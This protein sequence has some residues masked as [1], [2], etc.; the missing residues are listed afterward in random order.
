MKT[1]RDP[2]PDETL[3]DSVLRDE[4]WQAADATLK[5]QA[6]GAFQSGQ[7]VRRIRRLAGFAAVL[8][9]AMVIALRFSVPSSPV[10]I[11]SAA[12]P[13]GEPKSIERARDLT[14]EELLASFPEGS[15]FIAEIDGRKELIFLDPAVERIYV[16]KPLQQANLV[17][18][19]R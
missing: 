9:V 15:C 7:R 10:Q 13:A 11:Q 3:L 5:A 8:G 18:D 6:M 16:S 12:A 17:V 2:E 4:Q 14:D 1:N 19:L